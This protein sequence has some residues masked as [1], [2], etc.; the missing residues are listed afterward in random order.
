MREYENSHS[1]DK[2][3]RIRER[4]NLIWKMEEEEYYQ[5]EN[6]QAKSSL[7]IGAP[8]DK[9]EQEAD[10]VAKKAVNGTGDDTIDPVEKSSPTVQSKQDAGEPLMAKSEGG[11]LKGT[12]QLQAKLDHSKGSGDQLDLNTQKEMGSKIGADLS[13]VKIHTDSNAH[14][15]SEGINAKAFTHGQDIYFKQGNFDTNS[16]QGKELLAHELVHTQQQAGGINQKIQKQEDP[17][18][19]DDFFH[20]ADPLKGI[21]NMT[22]SLRHD[23]N[24]GSKLLHT[25]KKDDVFSIL[26]MTKESSTGLKWVFGYVIGLDGMIDGYVI[27]SAITIPDNPNNTQQDLIKKDA[28]KKVDMM[29]A[30]S[31]ISTYEI[32]DAEYNEMAFILDK[33]N[34][35]D[36]LASN[37]PGKD[38][39]AFPPGQVYAALGN[40]GALLLLTLQRHYN[41]EFKSTQYIPKIEYRHKD[42]KWENDGLDIKN[43]S[44]NFTNSP[45]IIKADS[46]TEAWKVASKYLTPNTGQQ[47]EY[48]GELYDYDRADVKENLL[49]ND[50]IIK[51]NETIESIAKDHHITVDE[52]MSSN[53]YT[54]YSHGAAINTITNKKHTFIPGDVLVIPVKKD[55]DE[56]WKL[57]EDQVVQDAYASL[58]QPESLEI[59]SLNISNMNNVESMGKNRYI[60]YR[61]YCIDLKKYGVPDGY[62]QSEYK[63]FILTY[64]SGKKNFYRGELP[65]VHFFNY[66]IESGEFPKDYP[67]T[68]SEFMQFLYAFKTELYEF[69]NMFEEK[70][71]HVA[72]DMLQTNRY[73]LLGEAE[74][75]GIFNNKNLGYDF[76]SVREISKDAKPAINQFWSHQGAF[77][78]AYTKGGTQDE[79]DPNSGYAADYYNARDI[80]NSALGALGQRKEELVKEDPLAG[81]P[82]FWPKSLLSNFTFQSPQ[83]KQ[84]QLPNLPP[85]NLSKKPPVSPI[86]QMAD[87]S[88]K[89]I[90]DRLRK[91][92]LEKLKAI[93]IAEKEVKSRANKK[94]FIWRCPEIID[95]TKWALG[96]DGKEPFETVIKDVVDEIEF[97]DAAINLIMAG[98]SIGLLFIPGGGILA[99]AA[100][101]GIQAYGMYRHY[102]ENQLKNKLYEAS[103]PYGK[104]LSND[105]K[106]L[107]WLW[108]DIAM[109]VADI[110]GIAK[111]VEKLAGAA[112][113]FF[114]GTEKFNDYRKAVREVADELGEGTERII[115]NKEEFVDEVA[116]KYDP[117][118]SSELKDVQKSQKETEL[119]L[120]NKVNAS[121]LDELKIKYPDAT[122][123]ELAGHLKIGKDED[124]YA[125]LIRVFGEQS[126]T[127]RLI[128]THSHRSEVFLK[129]IKLLRSGLDEKFFAEVVSEYVA[130]QPKMR[131]LISSIGKSKVISGDIL[132]ISNKMSQAKTQAGR[133]RV[134]QEK[135]FEKLGQRAGG[136]AAGKRNL[137]YVIGNLDKR[138]SKKI[139]EAWEA[140]FTSQIKS[141]A[142]LRKG[143]TGAKPKFFQAHHIV[144]RELETEFLEFFEEIGFK[145]DDGGMNGM[146]LAP[147]KATLDEAI[148]QAIKDGDLDFVKQFENRA[149]HKGSHGNYTGQMRDQIL[150]IESEFRMGSI[151]KSK[152]LERM[153][154][155]TKKTKET[156]SNNAGKT[157]N[158]IIL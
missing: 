57:Q 74:R 13:N 31:N 47:F 101:A 143:I 104:T 10:A 37:K 85:A 79:Y 106:D 75:Y 117:Q 140:K 81:A 55:E 153:L 35:L 27:K 90:A 51:Q 43:S 137:R 4:R 99:W 2:I 149:F 12:E 156:L 136:G 157:I 58:D 138:Y 132:N 11:L 82:E 158:D 97:E 133:L 150:F 123:T 105:Y 32:P 18:K 46:K 66:F 118:Y 65:L 127:F 131:N 48:D 59:S 122:E 113:K 26:Y 72:L 128:I 76:S 147:D 25:L 23:A 53:G 54:K 62:T 39:S 142:E 29:L 70:A 116:N 38:Q 52:L 89:Q 41:V 60:V 134:F 19:K 77:D 83:A 71:Y 91:I 30:G 3:R 126:D 34:L 33:M 1:N 148:Q 112:R 80:E 50:H 145:I 144:P 152:A 61:D 16:N 109:V 103:I 22:T 111:I 86:E 130:K 107:D 14:E 6:I 49:A 84:P 98:I 36:I 102:D 5:Q 110:P 95:E 40:D 78:A 87:E 68:Y 151:T 125:F 135:M 67:P 73:I 141:T 63:N 45:L 114:N 94:G 88:D 15:M 96:I 129:G 44:N 92:I 115:Q 124:L 64:Y 120:G 21:A 146:M 24:T 69:R 56:S 93:E 17:S 28:K 20:L 9:Y 7:E 108:M 154:N 119:S 139:V 121:K 42:F 100:S 8:D 155:L